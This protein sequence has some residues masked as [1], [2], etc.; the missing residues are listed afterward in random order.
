MYVQY[1][2]YLTYCQSAVPAPPNQGPLPSLFHSI[3]GRPFLILHH[4][5]SHD[6]DVDDD[7]DYCKNKK[8]QLIHPT[9]TGTEGT[10]NTNNS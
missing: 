1:L 5:P 6:D 3:P 4:S 9:F 10:T 7:T 8:L 2:Q